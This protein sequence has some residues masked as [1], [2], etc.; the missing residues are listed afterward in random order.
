MQ[1]RR[2]GDADIAGRPEWPSSTA[3]PVNA[4]PAARLHGLDGIRGLAA[5]FVV[6]HHCWL[7]SFPGF[8][9][10][11]GPWW[12]GWLV[13]GH[14]AVVIFIVLSG[15]SLS[16]APARSGWQLRSIREFLRRRAWRILPPYWAA[17][18]FSLAVAWW[19]V[20]QPNTPEPTAKSV[21][22]HGLLAQDLIGSPSPNGAL[23]SIA[24]EAQLYLVFPLLLLV[25][26]R[27]GAAVMLAS[28]TM[29]VVAIAAVAP[30]DTRVDALMRLTPQFAAL[31]A[32]GIVAAGIL[33]ASDRVRGLPWH[34][35][36]LIAV[37]P[38]V[39]LIAERGSAWTVDNFV[40][41][42]LALGPATGLLLAGVA[43]GRPVGLVRLLETRPMQRLGACSYSLYLT[44]SPIVV[45]VN[46]VVR[47]LDVG[48]GMPTFLLTLAIAVPLAVGFAMWFASLFEIPFQK[49][50]S[51][52]AWRK[53]ISARWSPNS[54]ESAAPTDLKGAAARGIAWKI[55]AEAIT[56]VTR[57]VV[58]LLLAHLLVPAEFGI[59]SIVIAFAIFVPLFADL[60]LGAALI[61]APTLTEVDRSTVF[62]TSLPLGLSFMALGISL[63][64]PL[65][66]IYGEPS[67]QP[68]FAAFSV[69]FLLGSLT[70]VPS[71]LLIRAMHFR[72][73]EIRVIVG[74]LFGAAV[75]VAL[76]FDGFG[77][78][79][80]VG[81]EIANR[82][83]SLV[84]IWLQ[85]HWRP[86]MVFSRRKLREQFAYGGTLF[87][88]FLLLQFSQTT[89]SLMVGR[90]LGASALGRL[91]LS[92]TLVYLPFN[93]IAGPIQEVMFPAFSRMQDEPTRILAALNR[94]NQ[95]LAAIAF[96]TLTGLAILAPE[97]TAI[98]LGSKWA[99]T[100]DVIR[101][102]ALAG[103]ALALQRVNYSVLSARGYTRSILRVGASTLGSTAAAILLAYPYGLVATIAALAV[104]TLVVQAVLMSVTADSLG[105]RF[106]DLARPLARITAA[107]GVMGASVVLVVEL[108]REV[109]A[110][111]VV[112]LVVG[113][114]T[115]AAVFVPLLFRLEPVL[116]GELK[117]FARHARRA[118]DTRERMTPG[119]AGLVPERNPSP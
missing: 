113:I 4:R 23:W 92:Q 48:S 115:G 99:G 104:Q 44:H 16:I 34:W 85:S 35:L 96:P 108:L 76:A 80:I 56:Q 117:G 38:V 86:K 3:D 82:A 118:S 49:H 64:W 90:F 40:W 6:L 20:A 72:A 25:L 87:G 39:L 78:W 41:V 12:L 100:E 26:L 5:L 66:A 22:V 33:V 45:T 112:V 51:W 75:A 88:A 62:W 91:T 59:A 79:A 65:A 7:L 83:I 89:Q 98:V 10:N 54:V 30:H 97:F 11:T 47:R 119:K 37:V 1:R 31:F 13:Y 58:L 114:A 103:M 77:A 36:A 67:L 52:A 42:D 63:S 105:A 111:N 93:R 60:G 21:A 84:T 24:I 57:L 94:I 102:L 9:I 43:A 55:A 29:I 17:L 71:A 70:S 73:L 68:M 19:I 8:P 110:G 74:T 61:Q 107:T 106:R 18:A 28:M 53:L 46:H 101:A 2:V 116:I 32:A 50:R 109:G 15:F 95:V 81:G 14:F 27:W 69:C